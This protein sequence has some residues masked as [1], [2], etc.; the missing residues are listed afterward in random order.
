[1]CKDMMRSNSMKDYT[2][3]DIHYI[4]FARGKR[5]AC[6]TMIK[7]K[8]RRNMKQELKNHFGALTH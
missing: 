4:A 3:F 1:M 2:A 5:K 6:E 8:A 7:R